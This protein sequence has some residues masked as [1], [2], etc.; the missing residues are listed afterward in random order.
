M[1]GLSQATLARCGRRCMTKGQPDPRPWSAGCSPT[2]G[3]HRGFGLSAPLGRLALLG[4]LAPLCPQEPLQQTIDG[5]IA[6][7]VGIPALG[8]VQRSP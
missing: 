8:D 6:K 1:T 7:A 4:R 5:R 2:A 3:Y